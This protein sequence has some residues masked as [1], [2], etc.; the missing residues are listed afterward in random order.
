V[1]VA[2]YTTEK[3]SRGDGVC[4][5]P[6]LSPGRRMPKSLIGRTQCYTICTAVTLGRFRHSRF[7]DSSI[8]SEGAHELRGSHSPFLLS[9][10]L[11]DLVRDR[12]AFRAWIEGLS[13]ERIRSS[14]S[15]WEFG[16][17]AATPAGASTVPR[18][19]PF[20]HPDRGEASGKHATDETP[21]LLLSE[22]ET[23]LANRILALA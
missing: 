12:D 20:D 6:S 21:R 22:F 5:R 13:L 7:A 10:N 17:L 19:R 18:R 1:N 8:I 3:V 15:W 4:T 16:S 23:G 11:R 9:S 2:E 14:W